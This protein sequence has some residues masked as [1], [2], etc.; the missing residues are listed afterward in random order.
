MNFNR[1]NVLRQ[2]DIMSDE[3][4][5]EVAAM[6]NSRGANRAQRKK[7][8]KALSKTQTIVEHAQKRLDRSSYKEYQNNLDVMMLRFY[9]VLGIVLKTRYHFQETEGNEQI[10]EMFELL[11]SYLEEY[12]ELSSE[13]V[14]RICYNTT[15]IE[16]LPTKDN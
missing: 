11:N 13:E 3:T 6:I 5:S 10:T 2:G 16:L 4:I 14:A 12:R 9:S 7:I 8:A 1:L 15:G